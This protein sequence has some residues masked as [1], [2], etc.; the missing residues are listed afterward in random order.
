MHPLGHRFAK[1]IS[2]GMPT[3]FKLLDAVTC[4]INVAMAQHLLSPKPNIIWPGIN[5]KLLLNH[6]LPLQRIRWWP[7]YAF[8]TLMELA[9]TLRRP[10]C[11]T[12]WLR[13]VGTGNGKRFLLLHIQLDDVLYMIFGLT[14]GP[15]YFLGNHLWYDLGKPNILRSISVHPVNDK[16]ISI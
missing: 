10:T 6:L 2:A 1:E 3:V 8:S 15:K 13:S 9:L 5:G 14:Y 7:P 16:W 4:L 11:G 12:L